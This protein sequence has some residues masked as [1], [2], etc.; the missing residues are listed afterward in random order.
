[1][2]GGIDAVLGS[3]FTADWRGDGNVWESWRRTCPPNSK[4]RKLF[5][6]VRPSAKSQRVL[7]LLSSV[8]G[9]PAESLNDNLTFARTVDDKFDF[10]ENPAQHYQQGHFFSDWR[11]ISV[12]YPVFSPAKA[13]G[14]ADIRIPSHYYHQATQSYAYGWDRVNLKGKETDDME[15]EWENKKDKIFWRGA[16]TGGGNSP[17]GFAAQYQRHR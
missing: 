11:T 9:E 10:C 13:Q 17:S 15:I 2:S 6:S 12:L 4:A 1:M 5:S 7:N 14:Y 8:K 3:G 16:T